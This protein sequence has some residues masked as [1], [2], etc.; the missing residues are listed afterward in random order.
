MRRCL[1]LVLLLFPAFAWA[2]LLQPFYEAIENGYD[3]WIYTPTRNCDTSKSTDT[4][5]ANQFQPEPKPLV[6]FLHGGSLCGHNLAKVRRYGTLHAIQMG[7]DLDAYVLAPQNPAGTWKPDRINRCL[8]YAIAHY[9]IDTTRIYILG[10]SLGGFGTIDYTAAYP[11]R[12]AAAMAICGGGHPKDFCPLNDVPLWIIHGNADQQV[13]ILSS[14]KVIRAMRNCNAE[15]PRLIF[16]ELNGINHSFPARLFY[17]EKTYDWLFEHR[18]D[19]EDRQLNR[20]YDITTSEM[21][22]AYH[23]LQKHPSVHIKLSPGNRP[24]RSPTEAPVDVAEGTV[25]SVV[26]GDNLT[27]ISRRYSTTINKICRLNGIERSSILKIGQQ[28]VVQ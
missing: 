26:K 20:D 24:R 22:K 11:N 3:F 25:Y 5:A 12:I 28:L 1:L 19:S 9:P 27:K 4:S 23:I 8:D 14:R 6:I 10:M 18:L 17:L 7:L 15:L 16:S 13:A 21:R 2:Q